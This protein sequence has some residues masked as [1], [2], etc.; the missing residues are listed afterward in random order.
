MNAP[1][2]RQRRSA[3]AESCTNCSRTSPAG[4]SVEYG[5]YLAAFALLSLPLLIAIIYIVLGNPV[6][7]PQPGL[8]PLVLLGALLAK[9]LR[10]ALGEEAGWREFALSLL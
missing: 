5:W 6:E 2:W 7:G 8:N 1:C 9:L 10:G 4:K 3:A